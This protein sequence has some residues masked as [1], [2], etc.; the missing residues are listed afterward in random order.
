MVSF[1]VH[2]GAL[3][4]FLIL[5]RSHLAP[6]RALLERQVHPRDAGILKTNFA[7]FGGQ[8]G[9][10]LGI[11]KCNKS[12]NYWLRAGDCF[13]IRSMS[14]PRGLGIEKTKIVRGPDLHLVWYIKGPT[15]C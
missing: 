4:I 6:K 14:M 11:I 2:C 10:L 5:F 1:E 7:G 9:T 8:I 13:C 3:V 15:R 12:E